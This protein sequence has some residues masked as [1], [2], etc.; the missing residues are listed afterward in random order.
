MGASPLAELD[1]FLAQSILVPSEDSEAGGDPTHGGV[2]T[3]LELASLNLVGCHV[4]VLSA[5]ETGLGVTEHGAGVLG[6]QY[7]LQASFAKAGLLSLW[8]VLDQETGSFM[9]DFYRTFLDRESVKA[10]YL[11]S[12]LKHCRRNEQRVYPYYWAASVLLDQEYYHPVF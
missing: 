2:L 9:I 8:K 5:C 7:A 11:T 6:F 3:A 10:G 12:V 1:N 4:V